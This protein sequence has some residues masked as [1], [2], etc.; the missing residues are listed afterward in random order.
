MR[1]YAALALLA[2]LIPQA[3]SAQHRGDRELTGQIG[4]MWGGT[5]EYHSNYYSFPPGD[6]HANANL[7][8]GGALTYYKTEGLGTEIAYNYQST[9]LI[10]RP[11]GLKEQKLTTLTT[12]YIQVNG[13]R[14]RPVNPKTEGF[15][16]GGLGTTVYS[17]QGYSTQWLFSIAA[18]L[19]VHV[20]LNPRTALRLQT[21]VLVPMRFTSGSFYFGSNGG[22]VSVGGG[23][24]IVQGEATAGLSFL[25]GGKP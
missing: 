16:L 23:T 21:R 10:I 1:R 8:Y 7:T 2:L 14:M 17:A 25:L 3:A 6:V 4:W 24:A 22:G 12:Q 18:G 19:G 11:Q 5:Q 20:R 13:L 9:D 15:V